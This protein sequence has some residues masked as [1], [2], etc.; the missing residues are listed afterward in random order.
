MI[1]AIVAD[2]WWVNDKYVPEDV[3]D[4]V[5]EC[6]WTA[7]F[8]RRWSACLGNRALVGITAVPIGANDPT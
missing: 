3:R 5:D 4:R 1:F 2:C 6:L 7:E 8:K